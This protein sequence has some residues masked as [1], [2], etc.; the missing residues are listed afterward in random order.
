[1]KNQGF[2]ALVLLSMVICGC[3]KDQDLSEPPVTIVEVP[4][5]KINTTVY[6][7]VIDENGASIDNY[8]VLVNGSSQIVDQEIFK[9]NLVE[10]NK[11]NQHISFIKDNREIAFANVSLI[12][13]DYNKIEVKS[14]PKW[15]NSTNISANTILIENN[16]LEVKVN[17]EQSEQI[18]FGVIDDPATM[19]QMGRWARG[20][21]VENYFLNPISAFYYLNTKSSH[22]ISI[23]QTGVNPSANKIGL[24]HLDN[25]FKQWV[26]IKEFN[27]STI[28]F[29]SDQNG[30][31]MLANYSPSIFLEGKISYTQLPVAFQNIKIEHENFQ[32][33]KLLT[34]ATGRWSTFTTEESELSLS[35]NNPCDDLIGMPIQINSTINEIQLTELNESTNNI[36][37]LNFRNIDC[38]GNR[39]SNPALEINFGQKTET[40]LFGEEKIHAVFATCGDI[41]IAAVDFENNMVGTSIEWNNEIQDELGVLSN[42]NDSEKGYSYLKINGEEEAL[43]TFALSENNGSITLS[44]PD[45]SIRLKIAGVERGSYMENQVNIFIDDEDFGRDGYYIK[46]ENSPVGCG[47]DDCY[48]SHLEDMGDGLSRVT[49]SG[50]LWMQTINNPTAGNY[51]VEGQIIIKQ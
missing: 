21:N 6:G 19:Q 51:P 47:I 8:D 34:S 17:K 2:I 28:S 27:S 20:V 5:T 10:A 48:I 45:N 4:D 25:N 41:K 3:Y 13:N 44:A 49:F 23:N 36:L 46:C 38:S 35:I 22:S 43:P 15:K 1:M 50:V 31:Y 40:Y 26:L 16:D 12:E 29:E 42:C 30:Y 11:K 14:F 32:A 37:P 9:L 18:T 7:V 33:I 39:L 24:F